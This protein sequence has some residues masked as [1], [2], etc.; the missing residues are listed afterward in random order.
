MEALYTLADLDVSIWDYSTG[1]E[2]DLDSLEGEMSAFM[3]TRFAQQYR[4]QVRK[5]T[6]DSHRRKAE[7]GFVTG[8]RVFGY[9]NHRQAKGETIRVINETEASVIRDIFTRYA[10]GDGAYTIAGA[11]N[12]MGALS[13][14]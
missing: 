6:R 9:D 7:Q 3:K 5:H 14:R 2:L 1:Q 11:L 12:R 4:D 10:A 13:P 8:G